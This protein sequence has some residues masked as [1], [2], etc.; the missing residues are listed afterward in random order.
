ML[1][2]SNHQLNNYHSKIKKYLN[3]NHPITKKSYQENK[4]DQSII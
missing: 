3:N 2:L 4:N 1:Y